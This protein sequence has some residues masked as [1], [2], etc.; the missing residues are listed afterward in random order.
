MD[1]EMYGTTANYK[2]EKPS[3]GSAS[4]GRGINVC[5]PSTI[6]EYLLLMVFLKKSVVHHKRCATDPLSGGYVIHFTKSSI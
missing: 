1:G 2:F 6:E 5:C 3:G 4:Q